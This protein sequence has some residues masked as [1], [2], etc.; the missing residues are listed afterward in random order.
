MGRRLAR[1]AA[2]LVPV[3]LA[4]RGVGVDRPARTAARPPPRAHAVDVWLGHGEAIGLDHAALA[5][6]ERAGIARTLAAAAA[7]ARAVTPVTVSGGLPTVGDVAVLVADDETVSTQDRLSGITYENL[8]A[9]SRRFIATFGDDYDQIAVFLGFTDRFSPFA[10]AYELPIKNDVS[11]LGLDHFDA[12]GTFGS[13]GRLKAML[14]MKRILAYGRE[15][16]NQPQN[17]LY[18]VWAQEAAHRWLTYFKVKPPG[19]EGGAP[20]DELLGRQG[21]HWSPLVQTDA[22]IMD[23]FAWRDNDDGTF[24]PVEA[25]KR[26]G[27]LD[28]YGM[29]LRTADEVPPFFVLRDLQDPDGRPIGKTGPVFRGTKYRGTRVDLTVA[30]IQRAL[31]PREP[32][33]DPSAQD[34]RMGVVLVVPPDVTAATALGEA[35]RIDRTRARWDE[36]YNEAGGGRGKVCTQLRRPC[37]GGSFAFGQPTLIERTVEPARDGVVA[38][39]EPFTLVVPVVNLGSEA[40]AATVTAVPAAGLDLARPIAPP[41]AVLAP[42]SSSAVT[43]DGRVALGTPCGRPLRIDLAANGRLGPSRDGVEVIVGLQRVVLDTL[44]GDVRGWKIDPDGQDKTRG[45]AWE[46]GTPE[47][48]LAFDF[49]MQPDGAWS[50]RNAFVTGAARGPGE[51]DSNDLDGV[52]TLESPPFSIAGLRDPRLRFMVHFVAADFHRDVLI[53]GANDHLVVLASADGGPWTE[54]DRHGGLDL[55]WHQ[56]II[57]L[58]DRLDAGQLAASA[59]RF[60]FVAQD[61]GGLDNVVEAAID[62]V[63]IAGIVDACLRAAPDPGGAD[64][65]GPGIGPPDSP[66]AGCACALGDTQRTRRPNSRP[67]FILMG[68]LLLLLMES[69]RN[70]VR[71]PERSE[72]LKAGATEDALDVD[73]DFGAAAPVTPEVIAA[74]ADE[75]VDDDVVDLPAPIIDVAPVGSR[76]D[77]HSDGSLV[78]FNALGAYL[79]ELRHHPL[80]DRQQEHELAVRFCTTGDDGAARRL[81][82]ANLRLVVK[83]AQE[84]RRAHKNLLDL[85][86]EGNIGLIQA[87]QKYDPYRGVKLSSYAAWWIRAYILKFILANWRIVKIGTTQAQRKL[88][89]NLRK[90]REKLEKAGFEVD[91]KHLAAALDVNEK[92]VIEMERRLGSSETSLDSPVRGDESGGRTQSDFVSAAATVRPDFQVEAGEFQE[93]LR[94]KLRSFGDMLKDRELDIFRERLLNDAP[95]TLQEIGERYGVSRERA[96]QIEERLK[97]KLRAFLEGELGDAVAISDAAD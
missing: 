53:P 24:T 94:Q 96:R 37:R 81:I 27:M 14:N 72:S 57:R 45:G 90:E 65:G 52:T 93:L 62:D 66:P 49:I 87:V 85:I 28:Q 55:G 26:Y 13:S 84:Y 3:L 91:A 23:G 30:D 16:A 79:Q 46:A 61:A 22:S 76:P 50:G 32:A 77:N 36:F 7:G 34:L 11:G 56:R 54:V 75:T 8:A 25:G 73:P 95:A 68:T 42:G 31:G 20:S 67:M 9:I 19:D 44:D 1:V 92:D 78:G 83:I 63:E 82:T 59:L 69:R 6:A 10:L 21:A 33:T 89:F 74:L 35:H 64:G 18:Y 15:S 86:Q 2:V 12:S 97:K 80:L 51:A 38:P 29:G 47:R 60:R 5:A 4:P 88:F 39:G 58:A 17:S 40:A 48:T 41:T 43:F 71:R 70:S